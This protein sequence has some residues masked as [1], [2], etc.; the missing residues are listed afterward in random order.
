MDLTNER[1]GTHASC[2][3]DRLRTLQSSSRNYWV[4]C[5]RPTAAERCLEDAGPNRR[6][7]QANCYLLNSGKQL[8][9]PVGILSTATIDAHI[10]TVCDVGDVCKA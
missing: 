9:L 3:V 4:A 10:L 5:R 8:I 7:P 2:F 6:H 1:Q